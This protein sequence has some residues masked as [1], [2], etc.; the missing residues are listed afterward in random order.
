MESRVKV[1]NHPLHPFLVHLPVGL[2]VTSLIFDIIALAS[3]SPP[4]AGASF[5]MMIFGAGFALLAA[6]P[7][8]IDYL[9]L[10]L[11]REARRLATYHMIL[12]LSIVGIFIADILWRFSLFER[13]PTIMYFVPTGPFILSIIAVLMLA[14][15]GWLGGQ[16]VYHHHLGVAVG[17]TS[18]STMGAFDRYDVHQRT[19][20]HA[21]QP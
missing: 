11:S 18:A 21:P 7:G 13:T 14:V 8:L 19:E 5:W 4:F 3:G 10:D 17:Q 9:S 12:N 16:L 2:W 20:T 6:I 1:L 15:S